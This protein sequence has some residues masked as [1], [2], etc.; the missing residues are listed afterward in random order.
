M[1]LLRFLPKPLV[2]GFV[3][4]LTVS[5]SRSQIT[6]V[7]NDQSTPIPGAGHDYI[8]ML[9]ET[10][11]PAN[12]SVS[13]RLNVPMPKGR[14]LSIPFAF[15]YD[16]NGV[17]HL[18][19]DGNGGSFWISDTSFLSQGG[20]A[21]SA[22]LLSIGDFSAPWFNGGGTCSFDSDFVFQ[23][24]AGGRHALGLSTITFSRPL[25]LEPS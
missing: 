20:W 17:H 22:P 8:K 6:N 1:S 14:A 3:L 16:S 21:Y 9:N 11:N 25:P 12:G 5:A 23:D 24:P 7:T 2:L 18:T 15:A 4:S 19:G 13:L 10:V